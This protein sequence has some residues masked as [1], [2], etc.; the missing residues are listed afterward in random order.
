MLFLVKHIMKHSQ[1]LIV[2]IHDDAS[3]S[4]IISENLSSLFNL[5]LI[6]SLNVILHFWIVC[7]LWSSLYSLVMCSC[8]ILLMQWKFSN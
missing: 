8:V 4:N 7:I 2:E 6:L 3:R 1:L 5:E